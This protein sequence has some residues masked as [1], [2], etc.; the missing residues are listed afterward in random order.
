MGYHIDEPDEEFDAETA[1]AV[2]A[3]QA[4]HQLYPYGVADFTTQTALGQAV[5]DAKVLVDRQLDKA[6]E[7]LTGEKL[8]EEQEAEE[9]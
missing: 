1:V 8:L 3:F 2:E 9:E 5:I 4:D 6:Y 7:L